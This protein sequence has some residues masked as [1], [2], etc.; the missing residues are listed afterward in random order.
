MLTRNHPALGAFR[1]KKLYVP[2]WRRIADELAIEVRRRTG[3]RQ[4]IC[5]CTACLA[6]DVYDEAKRRVGG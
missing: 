2:D 1:K 3:H 5:S 4:N 6:L